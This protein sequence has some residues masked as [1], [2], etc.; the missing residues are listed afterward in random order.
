MHLRPCQQKEGSI[1][2]TLEPKVLLMNKGDWS[3]GEN[4]EDDL[5]WGVYPGER[6]KE[7]TW[8]D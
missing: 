6:K 2:S 7:L 4:V 8:N 3:C 5:L 1:P